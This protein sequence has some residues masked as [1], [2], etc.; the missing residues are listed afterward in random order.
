MAASLSNDKNL[1]KVAKVEM[2]F[3][4]MEGRPSAFRYIG[5]LPISCSEGS[6]WENILAGD[7]QKEDAGVSLLFTEDKINE[8]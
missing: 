3:K 5:R 8:P 2:V 6:E 4:S 7:L 1:D